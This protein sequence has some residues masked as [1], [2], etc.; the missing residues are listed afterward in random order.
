MSDPFKGLELTEEQLEEIKRVTLP[1]HIPGCHKILVGGLRSSIRDRGVRQVWICMD[2]CPV[3]K[4]DEMKKKSKDLTKSHVHENE[5][6]ETQPPTSSPTGKTYITDEI[7]D[8]LMLV[9]EY[10]KGVVTNF[11]YE[12]VQDRCDGFYRFGGNAVITDKQLHV[13]ETAHRK[14]K[15][16]I[17]L[18]KIE[19]KK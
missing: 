13:V 8:K 18:G 3:K 19:V 7:A 17:L 16:G 6:P 4:A 9:L 14:V 12:V 10:G 2:E 15:C 5:R 11:E 1:K